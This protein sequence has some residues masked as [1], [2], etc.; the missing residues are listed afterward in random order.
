MGAQWGTQLVSGINHYMRD[1]GTRG[2]RGP[3]SSVICLQP[4]KYDLLCK[5]LISKMCEWRIKGDDIFL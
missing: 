1:N 4:I 5:S 2:S 3:P